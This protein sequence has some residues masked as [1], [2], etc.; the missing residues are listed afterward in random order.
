[1]FLSIFPTSFIP[2]IICCN[3][4]H[5]QTMKFACIHQEARYKAEAMSEGLL[6][7]QGVLQHSGVP[8][9]CSHLLPHQRIPRLHCLLLH[10]SGLRCTAAAVVKQ[11]L[12]PDCSPCQAHG[13]G[14]R[15]NLSCGSLWP[16]LESFF[17]HHC[18]AAS[19][20]AHFQRLSWMRSAYGYEIIT[21]ANFNQKEFSSVRSW[22]LPGAGG[23]LGSTAAAAKPRGCLLCNRE[24]SLDGNKVG[25]LN[26][27]SL[28]ACVGVI[29]MSHW[30][31]MGLQPAEKA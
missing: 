19:T 25:Q 2:I 10:C 20:W 11:H 16:P 8:M 1:M 5:E 30:S 4:I 7:A 9:R 15:F 24:S 14:E 12:A 21:L 26:E 3:Q 17:F 31:K 29:G 23:L 13:Q 6:P 22:A 27:P 18:N 28:K